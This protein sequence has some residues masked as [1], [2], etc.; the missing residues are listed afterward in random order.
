M[1]VHRLARAAWP[2]PILAVA[3]CG[4]GEPPNVAVPPPPPAVAVPRAT[5]APA[6]PPD[7]PDAT[8]KA[9]VCAR[10]DPCE[11]V[12][13]HA[14]GEDAAGRRLAAVLV[15]V[16][17]EGALDEDG[18]P[19]DLSAGAGPGAPPPKPPRDEGVTFDP[20]GETFEARS[21]SFCAR[22][23]YWRVVREG[24]QIVA[25]DRVAEICNDGHGAAGVGEDAVKVGPDSI[26]VS[27]S[28]GSN[29]RWS[30]STTY[31]L[32]SLVRRS[33]AWSG[34]WTM[35][36]NREDGRIDWEAFAGG[37]RWYS[38]PCDPG[39]QPLE[40]DM[41]D[42]APEYEEMWVPQVPLDPAFVEA[43][44]K[45]TK[46]GRCAASIDAGGDGGYVLSGKATTA[47]DAHVRVLAAEGG[48]LFVEVVDDT[49]VPDDHLEVWV[50]PQ[51]PSF[52]THCID[53]ADTTGVLSWDV[54]V[55][56]GKV[57]AGF[58]KPS[59]SSLVVERAA[60][61]GGVVRFRVVRP[62]GQRAVTIAY[63]D[64]DGGRKIERRIATSRLAGG[65]L[66]TL[67]SLFSTADH[68]V[69]T[70]HDGALVPELRPQAPSNP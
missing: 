13:E 66:A 33:Q 61:P 10:R 31:R 68:A 22:Y 41:T 63:A 70:V 52:D 9:L 48:P 15:F 50:A 47:A 36:A 44:W 60:D 3:A 35:G 37:V 19:P 51:L 29:W 32:S 56:D 6:P 42:D 67:G 64:S 45:T 11:L 25:A 34:Y 46:L 8:L 16:G 65:R 62:T 55:T 53:P 58:G 7:D 27:T 18:N 69:C 28:G 39:G 38:P 30:E 20:D 26:E 24:A 59:P 43:G 5:A 49:V 54:R 1:L 12:K 40:T 57:T 14:A 21:I 2:L 23:E 17:Y 4:A